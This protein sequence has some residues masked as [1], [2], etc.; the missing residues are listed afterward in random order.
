MEVIERQMCIMMDLST[1]AYLELIIPT[2]AEWTRIRKITVEDLT[3]EIEDVSVSDV[4]QTL[5]VQLSSKSPSSVHR[6]TST[7]PSWRP[8][9]TSRCQ[10]SL[11]ALVMAQ[12]LG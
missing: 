3:V 4:G 11:N 5:T 7:A 10:S 1:G 8:R 2:V 12:N 6:T 9:G